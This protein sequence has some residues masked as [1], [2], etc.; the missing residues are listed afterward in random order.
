MKKIINSSI[1]LLILFICL[2]RFTFYSFKTLIPFYLAN[3]IGLHSYTTD[4]IFGYIRLLTFCSYIISAILI[5]RVRLFRNLKIYFIPILLAL[6]LCVFN[7]TA[8]IFIGISLLVL[9]SKL[10]AINVFV[11][12]FESFD[13]DTPFDDRLYLL[14]ILAINVFSALSTII[15]GIVGFS[16]FINLAFSLSNIIIWIVFGILF[17]KFYKN[18]E[19]PKTEFV[20]NHIFSQSFLILGMCFLGFVIFYLLDSR[21]SAIRDKVASSDSIISTLYFIPFSLAFLIGIFFLFVKRFSAISKIILGLILL[22]IEGLFI[23][24][25]N[26][27]INNIHTFSLIFDS[28][29]NAM[30]LIIT[31]SILALI[32]I[33][34]KIELKATML[35]LFYILLYAIEYINAYLLKINLGSMII[36]SELILFG[37]FY[38][39]LRYKRLSKD[40]KLIIER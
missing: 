11:K 9:T 5:D 40:K 32:I 30:E 39:V 18:E 7:S 14:I 2:E 13:T 37:L 15:F 34:S 29:S 27:Y 23:Y 26:F 24:F 1:I 19:K 16:R 20:D 8:T 4:W 17:F 21:F 36:I 28:V 3:K 33:N 6:F 12:I 22:S 25:L 10:I 35:S 38:L 31:P